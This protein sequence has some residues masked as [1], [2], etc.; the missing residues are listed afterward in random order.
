M[1]TWLSYS[2]K[3]DILLQAGAKASDRLRDEA[4]QGMIT[5]R[6]QSGEIVWQR[7]DLRYSGPC[8]LHNEL[9]IANADQH[10]NKKGIGSTS[11]VFSLLDGSDQMTV[12]PITGATEP[13]RIVR[14]KRLQHDHRL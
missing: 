9:I 10:S 3:H 7:K 13:W 4:I 5:Y 12:N 2:T 8:I 1:G 14:G 6:G 11:T